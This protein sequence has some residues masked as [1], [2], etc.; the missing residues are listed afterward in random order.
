MDLTHIIG[1]EERQESAANQVNDPTVI[2]HIKNQNIIRSDRVITYD[3][4]M[5]HGASGSPMFD[6]EGR[7]VGV[8][9][10]G[11]V[12]KDQDRSVIECARPTA[13]IYRQFVKNLYVRRDVDLLIEVEQASESNR[14]L[15]EIFTAIDP[16]FSYG[17][18]Y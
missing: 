4:Y 3:T 6:A 7:V 8:H 12:L 5:M 16:L 15:R 14:E 18:C 10:A 13:Q 2:K 9:S 1:K 11:L 17:H